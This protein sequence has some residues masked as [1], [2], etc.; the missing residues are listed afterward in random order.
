MWGRKRYFG[1][2]KKE[3]QPIPTRP[4]GCRE[5]DKLE[6]AQ[7][8]ARGAAG[9][10]P[11]SPH[12]QAQRFWGKDSASCIPQGS[13]LCSGQRHQL[14]SRAQK[15]ASRESLQGLRPREAGSEWRRRMIRSLVPAFLHHLPCGLVCTRGRGSRAVS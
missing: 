1:K 15:Q 3:P 8:Q 12:L 5:E 7:S 2:L 4:S 13:S 14:S 11:P 9:L 6:G 10:W